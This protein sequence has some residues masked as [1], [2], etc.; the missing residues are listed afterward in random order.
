MELSDETKNSMPGVSSEFHKKGSEK[1][2]QG[3]LGEALAYFDKAIETDPNSAVY[4][5]DKA[6]VLMRLGKFKDAEKCLKTVV[7]Q[8]KVNKRIDTDAYYLL[9]LLYS[10]TGQIIKSNYYFMKIK[11]STKKYTLPNDA[12]NSLHNLQYKLAILLTVTI[13]VVFAVNIDQISALSAEPLRNKIWF[14]SG[15]TDTEKMLEEELNEGTDAQTEAV[16]STQKEK[17]EQLENKTYKKR[18]MIAH[19]T[20][21]RVE[22][23]LPVGEKYTLQY[24][25][26]GNE[27]VIYEDSYSEDGEVI[28]TIEI[29]RTTQQLPVTEIIVLG[30]MKEEEKAATQNPVAEKSDIINQSETESGSQVSKVDLTLLSGLPIYSSNVPM[31]NSIGTYRYVE[32]SNTGSYDSEYTLTLFN[33]ETYV[34]T[35]LHYY[36]YEDQVKL[37]YASGYFSDTKF[38]TSTKMVVTFD[39]TEDYLSKRKSKITQNIKGIYYEDGI[40]INN[41]IRAL[42]D[43]VHIIDKTDDTLTLFVNTDILNLQHVPD[44]FQYGFKEIVE[45]YDGVFE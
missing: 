39:S 37:E 27:I 7:A 1:A 8:A 38:G 35:S 22:S 15:K 10:T 19:D 21:Y 5:I 12:K 41:Y 44:E 18:E 34:L 40:Q 36:D 3:R 30:T 45:E 6:R 16:V 32:N 33:D 31:D 11:G 42:N 20:E 4:M 23:T 17:V 13:L 9:G 26:D 24:G 28:E 14:L 43:S 25:K 29:S 2:E